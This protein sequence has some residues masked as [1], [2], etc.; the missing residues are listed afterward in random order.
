VAAIV[1]F[2]RRSRELLPAS[3]T[4]R[5]D[6][7]VLL[8][9][10][11]DRERSYL[12]TWPEQLLTADQQRAFAELLA[13]RRAG[14]PVA[15][16]VGRQAFWSLEL[17]VSPVTL[18]PRPE[19]ELLVETALG[20]IEQPRARVL[21][22]GTGTGAIALALAAERPEW[23]VVGVDRV[24]EALALASDN[25]RRHGLVNV[26]FSQSNWFDQVEGVFH[27]IVSNP[28]YIDAEDP[29]LQRGDV[30]HEPRSALVSGRRGL[31]DIIDIIA[32]A[33]DH[34]VDGGWLLLE[35]GA[36][37]GRGV[38]TLLLEAGFAEVETR[39][40]LAGLDRVSSG[41]LP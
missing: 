6:V 32:G 35:H 34:L 12:Y 37:Q 15:Y 31:A 19:T 10:A 40:D 26:S 27:L 16:I 5:L 13:R 8:C 1:D 14:E 36:N 25:Q 3:D 24:A 33:A 23:Q 29:H 28:P 9:A 18:I 22:L 4:P 21:D 7:E 2:L 11:L 20:K 39:R 38:R 17:A 41:R 30:R